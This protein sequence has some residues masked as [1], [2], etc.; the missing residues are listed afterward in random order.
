MFLNQE[1]EV[2]LF[3][4]NCFLTCAVI[5]IVSSVQDYKDNFFNLLNSLKSS[6]HYTDQYLTVFVKVHITLSTESWCL[7]TVELVINFRFFLKLLRMQP[8]SLNS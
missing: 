2:L 5:T 4:I 6:T 3:N 7:I 1:V 8:N